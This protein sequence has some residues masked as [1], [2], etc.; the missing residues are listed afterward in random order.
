M[1]KKVAALITTYYPASHADVIVTKFLKG[2]P[3]DDGLRESRVE[4]AS[5]YL[6]QIHE[7]DVGV[8]LAKQHE[9][10]IYPSITAALSL[11]GSELAVD[12]VLIIGE[13]GDYAW[14]EK[15]QHLYPRRYFFEQVCG[16]LARSGR[17]IPVFSDKH[18][19]WSWEHARWMYDRALELE[20]PFM[21]GSSLPISY[22]RPWLEYELETPLQEALSMAYGG[23]DSYGFHALETLQCMAERR[24]G[25][26]TGVS[27][28]QCLEGEAVW[29]A[30]AEGRW[31]AELFDAALEHIEARDEGDVREHCDKPTVY[32]LEHTDGLQTATFLLNGFLSGWGYAGRVDGDVAG[33]EVYL[34][35]DPHP[36]FSYLGLNAEEMI[37]TGKPVYPVERTL[38]VSGMLEALLT[39]RHQGHVRLE[40]PHLEVS[41]QSYHSEPVRPRCGRPT[42]AAAVPWRLE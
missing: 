14:N 2:F 22:R 16:V 36:H 11:G 9:V 32:L 7:R 29:A 39:S 17:S 20:V 37:V 12:G 19:S 21:A 30:G 15:E 35:G 4:V 25:G 6:D 40:T 26:E 5:L 1:K 34:H 41:Y 27:A 31:S 8:A 42:G 3:T 10:P 13:H 18:L 38:L 33:C 23:L 24:V 28:V